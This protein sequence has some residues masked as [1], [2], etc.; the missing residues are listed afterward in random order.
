[1]SLE[2]ENMDIHNSKKAVEYELRKLEEG[3]INEEEK[4]NLKKYYTELL[5]KG[6]SYGRIAKYLRTI[7]K[8][9]KM[10]GKPFSKATKDD[11]IQLVA[12]IERNHSFSQWTKHDYKLI[13]KRYY[14][15]LKGL[16]DGDPFPEEVRWISTK[17][18][19][20]NSKLPEDILTFEEVQKIAQAAYT[21]RDKAF[22]ITLFESGA[23]IGEILPLRIKD[24]E[25]GENFC[26]VTLRG[27]TGD[28]KI[29]LVLSYKPLAE[30]LEKHPNKNDENAYLWVNYNNKKANRPLAYQSVIRLLRELA[31]KAG[32]KKKV[33]PHNFRHSSASW[34]A[35]FFSESQLKQFYGW[36]QAS[37]MASVYV[38]LSGKQLDESIDK[39]FGIESKEEKS[40]LSPIVKCPRCGEE[41]DIASKFCKRC[42]L[43]L[44]IKDWEK[45]DKL[46]DLLIEYFKVLGEIFPQAKEKFIEIAKKKGILDF[47]KL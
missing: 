40:K 15:W 8:L 25:F 21:E 31:E 32:I 24:L 33:N 5:A 36:S 14:R 43:P 23:R 41:N 10:L 16:S 20:V 3:D 17:I 42:G 37:R 19:N 26:K 35:V 28:R 39:M 45:M 9:S 22:V 4:L 29:K 30:W 7:R 44:D 12:Q 34:R 6:I 47:F 13:L 46:E 38:H 1:M 11:F 18:R 2:V 27:K